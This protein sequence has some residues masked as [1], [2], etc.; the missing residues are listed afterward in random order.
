LSTERADCANKARLDHVE[1][2][3]GHYVPAAST[4]QPIAGQPQFK[5][6]PS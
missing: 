1:G 6:R 4:A 2:I 3:R 5:M